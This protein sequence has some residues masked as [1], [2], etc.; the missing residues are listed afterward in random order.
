MPFYRPPLRDMVARIGEDIAARLPGAEAALRRSVL[1]V[2][3]RV[4]AGAVDGLYGYLTWLARQIFPDTAEGVYLDRWAAIWGVSRK[5]AARAFGALR[6]TGFAGA[7]VP[8]GTAWAWQGGIDAEGQALPTVIVEATEEVTLPPTGFALVSARA[9]EAGAGSTLP[10]GARLSLVNALPGIFADARVET[11][12]GGGADVESDDSLRERLL[13]RIQ[14][15]PEGGAVHDYLAWALAVPGVSRAWIYPHRMGLGTVGVAVMWQSGGGAD[16]TA[17]DGEL[18]LVFNFI[19]DRRPVTAGVFVFALQSVAIN[20]TIRLK[21]PSQAVKDAVRAN[22]LDL[23][24][25]EG[26]PGGVLLIS[27]IR[28]AISTALGEW[29]HVVDPP[30][31]PGITSDQWGN[32]VMADAAG[33]PVLGV[34]TWIN[35]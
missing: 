23:F 10:V 3:T 35:L 8:I 31:G 18:Q 33:I 28:E 12:W 29:D 30:T 22:L 25:R 32:A 5:P 6:V 20:L 21:P 27:H 9:A 15:P 17:T 13:A 14:R 34:I 26:A 19:D 1:G 16:R 11:A 7:V 4:F 2:L 24:M